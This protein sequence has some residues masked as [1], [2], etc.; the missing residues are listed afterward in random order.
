MLSSNIDEDVPRVE[1]AFILSTPPYPVARIQYS[2]TDGGY[3]L[4]VLNFH[5]LNVSQLLKY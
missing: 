2:S 5:Y 3:S 4:V 1:I